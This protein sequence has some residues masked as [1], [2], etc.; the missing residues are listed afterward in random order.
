CG[1]LSAVPVRVLG[2]ARDLAR[3]VRRRELP[4][5][6]RDGGKERPVR[7]ATRSAQEQAAAPADPRAR[8]RKGRLGHAPSGG[9]GTGH[10][11]GRVAANGA[12]TGG[13]SV[14]GLGTGWARGSPALRGGRRARGERG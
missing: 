13:G 3:R 9:T 2:L 4:R 11:L 12:R 8:G 7:A 14:G 5:R 6:S 10:R 1:R